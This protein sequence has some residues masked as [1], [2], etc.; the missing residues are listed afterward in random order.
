M[1]FSAGKEN[2]LVCGADSSEGEKGN[3]E[4]ACKL[5]CY[6]VCLVLGC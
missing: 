3:E 1:G 5:H 4:G 6:L 2:V